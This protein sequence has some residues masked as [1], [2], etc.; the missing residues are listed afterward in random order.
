MTPNDL[1]I[2]PHDERG[3]LTGG[4]KLIK[5]MDAVKQDTQA[6]FAL[7]TA[8][9]NDLAGKSNGIRQT[10]QRIQ[11]NTQRTV[12]AVQQRT[13]SPQPRP[14]HDQGGQNAQPNQGG[15]GLPRPT[16]DSGNLGNAGN[17]AG[18][19]PPRVNLIH[20]DRQPQPPSPSPSPP[21]VNLIHP[22]RTTA[23]SPA[24]VPP[25]APNQDRQ[26]DD[27]GRFSSEGKQSIWDR[28]KNAIK[29][30]VTEANVDTKNIDP[31][32]DAVR[33]LGEAMSPLFKVGKAMFKGVS[34]LFG[35]KKKQ[36]PPSDQEQRQQTRIEKL[37]KRIAESRAGA[38]AR[39]GMNLLGGIGGALRSLPAFLAPLLGRLLLPALGLTAAFKLGE[40]LGNKIY[41][42]IE[43]ALSPLIDGI[44]AIPDTIS[45]AWQGVVDIAS[46]GIEA[47][48][49]GVKGVTNKVQGAYE[50]TVQGASNLIEKGA[51]ASTGFMNWGKGV[52]NK[53]VDKTA[54]AMQAGANV[55]S[56]A[57]DTVRSGYQNVKKKGKQIVFD[58]VGAAMAFQGSSTL[59]GMNDSQTRAFAATVMK[60]ESGGDQ[61]AVN[62]YGFSGQ[63]QFGADA[64]S[65]EGLI[66]RKKLDAAKKAAGKNWYKGGMHKAFLADNS[67]W[68]IAGG[69][70]AFLENKKMQDDAFISYTNKNIAAGLKSGALKQGEDPAKIAAYAKAA[71]LKGTG[72]ANKLFLKGIDSKDAYGMSAM[73]YANDAASNL[74]S[75]SAKVDAEKAE[76]KPTTTN[77]APPLLAKPTTQPT[78]Y[79][80]QTDSLIAAP[81]TVLAKTA[82]PVQTPPKAA[83]SVA[84]KP[85][86]DA[87][88]VQQQVSSKPKEAKPTIAQNDTISQNVADR[89]LAHAVT[90]GLGMDSMRYG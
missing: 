90:G 3:F 8:K 61:R 85:I 47:V 21:R 1:P 43:P 34:W 40:W 27:N 5:D 32:V 30:G 57:M 58:D 36:P 49:E 89:H 15:Q 9:L 70:Q 39:S 71:H 45:K 25:P 51:N 24:P 50:A 77:T 46:K 42:F 66:D 76:K 72:G 83:P 80:K 10:L 12:E 68:T 88:K 52:Y 26:R 38:A 73:K 19:Q 79:G 59:K 87:P 81:M 28:F 65:G 84:M 20:P 55:A 6:I 64:L 62:S 29:G 31:T 18:G 22:D 13:A 16:I 4:E 82:T 33:E 44:A 63:Y 41:S 54:G 75:L 60:T 2:L 48:V 23:P 67:N 14:T 56:T 69:Q 86:P 17:A 74:N 53:A 37:L 7:L 35:K 11:Q 78:S